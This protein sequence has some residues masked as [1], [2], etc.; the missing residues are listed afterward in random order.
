[1]GESTERARGPVWAR[2]AAKPR[3][4]L[5]REA[6]VTAGLAIADAEG[7][8]AVSIRR[9]AAELGARTM[10]LYTHIGSKEDLLDLMADEA[11]AEVLVPGELPGDWREALTVIAR[12][13]REA[14]RRHPWMIELV[15]RRS[16]VGPNML[17]H[18][19]QT[20]SALSGLDLP[21]EGKFHVIAAVNDY[22]SGFVLREARERMAPR[23]DGWT[24][25]ERDAFMRPYLQR[26]IDTGEFPNLAPLMKDGIPS[27]D[28]NFERGLR[29]LLDGIAR[30]LGRG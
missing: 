26:L 11:A 19:E 4:A 9:V 16:V 22:S 5:T 24:D 29:W 3:S 18:V 17:R 30:D 14:V 25:A 20:M 13:E 8:D 7:L 23:R 1:M 12:R 15:S 21:I 6:I 10:S 27:T 2:D 28:D